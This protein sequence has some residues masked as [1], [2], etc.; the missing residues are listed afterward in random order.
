M[1]QAPP[2]KIRRR[3]TRQKIAK[4]LQT[5]KRVLFTFDEV[6]NWQRDNEYLCGKY[7]IMSGSYRECLHS[8][9]Y[10]HNQTGNI[11]SHLL[12]AIVFFTYAF[13]VYERITTRYAT[14][15]AYDLLAFG[16][17]I[18]SAI[19]CFGFSATF[20][21]FGNHS[22]KVY[23]TWLLLDL[24]GIFVLIAG[25][26]YSGTYYGFYCEPV[27]W[28]IYSTGVRKRQY[29]R[30]YIHADMCEKIT[31]IVTAAG[32]LCSMPR[33]RT[34]KWRWARATLF[35]AIGWSGAFPMTQAAQTFGIEQ[36]HKQMGWWYFIWEGL[37]YISGAIIYAVS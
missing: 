33:F 26:V 13:H 28:I 7:R 2:P 3:S 27:Y 16:I 11:Y 36:S 34:P 35:C 25:T 24:Y 5:T 15:D 8:L 20:H 12:G 9:L 23:H 6:E 31:V 32:T 22:S 30:E 10:L 21:I 1:V 18:G 4:T 14:A 29:E 19:I 17:F 37:S